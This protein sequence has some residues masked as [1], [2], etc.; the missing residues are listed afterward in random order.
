[1]QE[2][3]AIVFGLARIA[4]VPR[5]HFA[6]PIQNFTAFRIDILGHRDLALGFF[7]INATVDHLDIKGLPRQNTDNAQ[8]NHLSNRES[9][10]IHDIHGAPVTRTL[11]GTP[12]KPSSAPSANTE[13]FSSEDS[14]LISSCCKV[15][16]RSN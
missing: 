3:A 10:Q 11:V 14:L 7:L 2:N 6:I 8:H 1:M 16:S 13:R 12:F 4:Q 9:I 15:R 5:E